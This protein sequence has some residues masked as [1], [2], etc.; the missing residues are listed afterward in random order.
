MRLINN[1]TIYHMIQRIQS[2]YLFLAVV[3]AVLL[4]VFPIAWF[5]GESYNLQFHVYQLKDFVPSNEPIFSKYYLVP[6]TILTSLLVINPLITL[7]LYKNLKRQYAFTRIN[8]F[9]SILHIGLT[10]FFYI[11]QIE[12]V[13]FVSPDYRLGVFMPLAALV[14]S[15]LAMR[16]IAKDIK[17][18]RSVD[19]IR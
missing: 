9:L 14:F 17:I 12:K 5:Y 2:V 3:S 19:R 6:L 11:D 16:G 1:Y 4:F 8:I 7:F 15:F 18:I 13:V 10:F